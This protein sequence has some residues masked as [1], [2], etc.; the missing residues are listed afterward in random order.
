[1][2]RETLNEEGKKAFNIF[3]G[4]NGNYSMRRILAFILTLCSIGILVVGIIFHA[5]WKVILVAGGLPL[6]GSIILLFFTTWGDVKQ[7]IQAVKGD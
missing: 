1:M 5:E 6:L 7:V 4:V 3:Q 2:A